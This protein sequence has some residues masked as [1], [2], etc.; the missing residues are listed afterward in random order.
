MQKQVT[1]NRPGFAGWGG[2]F[3]SAL[4]KQPLRKMYPRL[5]LQTAN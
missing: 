1:Q 2:H 3:D 4:A 5:Q